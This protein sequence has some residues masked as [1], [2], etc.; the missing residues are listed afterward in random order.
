MPEPCIAGFSDAMSSA[1]VGRN[2][3][4]YGYACSGAL[5]YGSKG[6]WT[7]AFNSV[8]T[9]AKLQLFHLCKRSYATSF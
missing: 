3:R 2:Y 7:S 8:C 9:F 6:S 1:L 5:G 4:A